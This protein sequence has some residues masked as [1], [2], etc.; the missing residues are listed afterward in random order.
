MQLIYGKFLLF[1]VYIEDDIVLCPCT[2]YC[3]QCC[4]LAVVA[5][6]WSEQ[7]TTELSRGEL[8]WVCLGL[9]VLPKESRPARAVRSAPTRGDTLDKLN[10]DKSACQYDLNRGRYLLSTLCHISAPA[11]LILPATWLWYKRGMIKEWEVSVAG[12]TRGR[13]GTSFD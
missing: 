12:L 5:V 8:S 2:V 1:A 13:K 3:G 6:Y 9:Y 11:G 4:K 7:N 10:S